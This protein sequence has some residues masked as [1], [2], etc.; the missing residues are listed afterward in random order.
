M[1]GDSIVRRLPF[2]LWQILAFGVIATLAGGILYYAISVAHENAFNDERAFRVLAEVSTQ[3]KS[4]E[5]SRATILKNMPSL[6]KRIMPFCASEVN[7]DKQ[8]TAPVE[9]GR[10]HPAKAPEQMPHDFESFQARLDMV[11]ARLCRTNI[12][13]ATTGPPTEAAAKSASTASKAKQAPASEA[14]PDAATY[15]PK[16][17]STTPI[18]P[19]LCSEITPGEVVFQVVGDRLTT[20]WCP[21]GDFAYTLD[22][23]FLRATRRFIGQDFFAETLLTLS[24]GAVLGEFARR[25]P[26]S[27]STRVTLQVPVADTVNIVN[28]LGLIR[29]S[30]ATRDTVP[31]ASDGTPAHNIDTT[32][33]PL[34]QD[35][36]VENR[37]FRVYALPFSGSG[38]F[39]AAATGNGDTAPA[40]DGALYVVGL[41]SLDIPGSVIHA[42]WPV[43]LGLITLLV[44]LCLLGWPLARLVQSRADESISRGSVVFCLAATLLIPALLI[45]GAAAAW[46]YFQL[47]AWAESNATAYARTLEQSIRQNLVDGARILT[48]YSK[49]YEGL[50]HCEPDGTVVVSVSPDTWDIKSKFP[51]PAAGAPTGPILGFQDDGTPVAATPIGSIPQTPCRTVQLQAS[52]ERDP[53]FSWSPLRNV[54]ALDDAGRRVG[55]SFTVFKPV[56]VKHDLNLSSREYFQALKAVEAWSVSSGGSTVRVVAQRLFNR[57]DG[58]KTLQL[59]VPRSCVDVKY[60]CG[61]ITGDMRMHGFLVAE[62]P[63]LMRFVVIDTQ[64]GTAVF[65]STDDRSLS[66]NFFRESELT[67]ALHAAIGARRPMAYAGRYVG[68]PHNFFYQPIEGTPW[69]VVVF[70]PEKELAD[71]PLRAG[72]AALSAYVGAALGVLLILG[73]GHWLWCRLLTP[74]TTRSLWPYGLWPSMPLDRLYYDLGRWQPFLFAFLSLAVAIV[75]ES[76]P[77]SAAGIALGVLLVA[78]L[79]RLLL[80]LRA[81]SRAKLAASA[82]YTRPDQAYA[83]LLA[84]ALFVCAV[85]PAY[86]FFG[87]FSQLQFEGLLRDEF[88]RTTRQMEHRYDLIRADL[89]RWSPHSAEANPNRYPRTWSV[90]NTPEIGISHTNHTQSAD[91]AG[92]PV[93]TQ[94]SSYTKLIWESVAETPEQRRRVEL[95]SV[96]KNDDANCVLVMRGQFERCTALLFDGTTHATVWLKRIDRKLAIGGDF[97]WGWPRFWIVLFGFGCAYWGTRLACRAFTQGLLGL[98][99][100]YMPRDNMLPPV[101]T[102]VTYTDN[103]FRDLW[104]ALKESDQRLLFQLASHHLVNPKN[105][106][107]VQRLLSHKGLIRIDRYPRLARPDLEPL[108]RAAAV[109]TH[110]DSVHS[111]AVK[112]PWRSMGPVLFIILMIVIA[113]LSW[114]AGGAMKAL[115]AILLATVAFLSQIGQLVNIARTGFLGGGPKSDG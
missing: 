65:H 19:H 47:E 86:F 89:Q 18:V 4:L 114:A 57:T 95:L 20:T 42:L 41:R 5:A 52:P 53:I 24:D 49:V 90:V 80:R 103:T 11:D 39:I 46:N 79:P 68:D 82:A 58:S 22:E 45:I 17:E 10:T 98:Q 59:A 37:K 76:S 77:T 15:G 12:S 115:S 81:S 33:Q 30:S 63:P 85:I 71:L 9:G 61:I 34:A 35:L 97:D 105:E 3:F 104:H 43:G 50:S 94:I 66:E 31:A 36:P 13:G 109:E 32:R 1:A 60:F 51:P 55:P 29:A 113:W 100:S 69:S 40:V 27:L 107:V 112:S 93:G 7:L 25:D 16:K 14:V 44:P 101:I 87:L 102:D 108:I 92:G 84:C 78:A 75:L 6:V 91:A 96:Y 99:A 106:R 64:T 48:S 8:S 111:G 28:A 72:S 74:R 73:V 88:W 26:N 67:P 21:A 83:E 56:D 62:P 54:L 70:F 23:P 2:G 110:M 38:K